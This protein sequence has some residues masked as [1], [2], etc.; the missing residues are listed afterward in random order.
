MESSAEVLLRLVRYNAWANE[1]MFAAGRALDSA[2]LAG[3][4]LGRRAASKRR[5]APGGR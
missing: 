4:R 2:A 5:S 1:R 3:R